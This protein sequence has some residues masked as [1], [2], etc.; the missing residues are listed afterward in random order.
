MIGKEDAIKGNI[1]FRFQA[2][3]L[4][5]RAVNPHLLRLLQG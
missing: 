1:D 5:V 4:E 3:E 2:R